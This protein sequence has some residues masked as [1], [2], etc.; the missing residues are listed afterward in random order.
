VLSELYKYLEQ[1]ALVWLFFRFVI[2]SIKDNSIVY[3]NIEIGFYIVLLLAN[4]LICSYWPSSQAVFYFIHAVAPVS[5]FLG[6][7]LKRLNLPIVTVTSV[8]VASVIQFYLLNYYLIVIFYL[9]AILSL[10]Y[11]ANLLVRRSSR[12]IQKSSLFVV[13]ALDLLFTLKIYIVAKESIDWVGSVLIGSMWNF[14]LFMFALT[15]II[16]HVKLRRFFVA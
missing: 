1:I 3:S 6:I 4:S 13:L 12:E 16:L 11:K 15:I 5:V 2:Y 14:S 9:A 10:V 8:V 7:I